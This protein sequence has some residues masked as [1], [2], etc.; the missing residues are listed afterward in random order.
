[1]IAVEDLRRSLV[2]QLGCLVDI[3]ERATGA[4]PPR[5]GAVPGTAEPPQPR[6][7]MHEGEVPPDEALRVE[8]IEASL[9]GFEAA[10][11]AAERA[12]HAKERLV[13]EALAAIERAVAARRACAAARAQLRRSLLS[14]LDA[15]EAPVAGRDAGDGIARARDGV[16]VA[17][18]QAAGR[19]AAAAALRKA[20]DA[21]GRAASSAVLAAI[22]ADPSRGNRGFDRIVAASARM[23]AERAASDAERILARALATA[24][25][26]PR[27]G[28]RIDGESGK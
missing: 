1:M 24:Q 14:T 15:R 7:A 18:A 22:Q 2:V 26:G 20:A 17:E 3:H 23:L 19:D 5:A 9:V 12:D 10:I 27:S 13:G 8:S 28:L 16:R 25:A 6:L 11:R 21:A 4:A